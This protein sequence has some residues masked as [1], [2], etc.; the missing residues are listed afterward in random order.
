MSSPGHHAEDLFASLACETD[1][2]AQ[3]MTELGRRVQQLQPEVSSLDHAVEE[4]MS[5]VVFVFMR[6]VFPL[7][8]FLLLLMVLLATCWLPWLV[9][10]KR[11]V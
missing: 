9:V 1:E 7:S 2:L 5:L 6:M 8:G 3:R 11:P 10:F 4:G